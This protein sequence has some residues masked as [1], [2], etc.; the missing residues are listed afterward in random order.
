MGGG[1]EKPLSCFIHQKNKTPWDESS[2]CDH[3]MLQDI[4]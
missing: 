2:S 1:G 3:E 4:A